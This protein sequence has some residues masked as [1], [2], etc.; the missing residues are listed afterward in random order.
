MKNANEILFIVLGC[1]TDDEFITAQGT[2]NKLYSD[3]RVI[4]APFCQSHYRF[5]DAMIASKIKEMILCAEDKKYVA[6]LEVSYVNGQCMKVDLISSYEA[7][8]QTKP[9]LCHP[10]AGTVTSFRESEKFMIADDLCLG[11][12]QDILACVFS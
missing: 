8:C 9:L 11:K 6:L 5:A 4:K 12:R 3:S 10:T 2:L 1:K 7:K